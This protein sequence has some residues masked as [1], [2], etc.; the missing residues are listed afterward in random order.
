MLRDVILVALILNFCSLF[1]Q[2]KIYYNN[3]GE[4][5]LGELATHYR[6]GTVDPVNK[7]FVGLVKDFDMKGNKF[8][9]IV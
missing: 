1:G 8:L 6:I 4:I 2:S 3:K 9:E 7:V 5:T